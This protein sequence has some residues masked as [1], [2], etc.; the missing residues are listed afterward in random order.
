M[1][2]RSEDMNAEVQ[3]SRFLDKHFYTW[4]EKQNNNISVERSTDPNDQMKGID[5]CI[6]S[7]KGKLFIDEKAQLY[8]INKGLPTFAF[9]ISFMNRK[10]ELAEG[11][12][13]N[14]ELLTDYYLLIW[15][16]ATK[17]ENVKT[18]DYTRLECLLIKKRKI[19]NYLSNK[20]WNKDR[21]YKR[22]N[23]IRKESLFGKIEIENESNFY[24]FFSKPKD[25]SEQ[26][27]NIVIR[28]NVLREL[29]S[30]EYVV[31]KTY[32]EEVKFF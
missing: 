27:I 30:R 20:G 19:Q 5:I 18:E 9:E 26:P 15:P 21:I 6:H 4:L 22:A 10:K 13:F 11:W 7:E 28:K 16:Y 29:A 32:V 31:T 23:E 24:F 25:Y 2:R 14:N 12:L 3:L 17:K 1:S 8:F